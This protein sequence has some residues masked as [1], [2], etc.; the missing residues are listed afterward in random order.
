MSRALRLANISQ[1][2]GTVSVERVW[3]YYKAA[4]PVGNRIMAK[5]YFDLLSGLLFARYCLTHAKA[6]R[7][8]PW[9]ERDSLMATKLD[10]VIAYA[11]DGARDCSEAFR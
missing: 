9:L 5:D 2:S 1:Q 10:A 6:N 3:S 11:R 4:L 7:L 8:P